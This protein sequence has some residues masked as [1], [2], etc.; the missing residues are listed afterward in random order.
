MGSHLFVCRLEAAPGA[1][2]WA[3][4]VLYEA[5]ANDDVD[6][7]MNIPRFGFLDFYP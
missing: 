1:D 6:E 4:A 2:V 3:M 5:V 7:W